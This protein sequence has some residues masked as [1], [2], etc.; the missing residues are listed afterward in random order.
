MSLALSLVILLVYNLLNRKL[1]SSYNKI[2]LNISN[3][4]L[5]EDNIRLIV[6]IVSGDKEYKS[7]FLDKIFKENEILHLLVLS[8]GNVAILIHF[9]EYNKARY[10][11]TYFVFK[12]LF[13]SEYFVFTYLQHP[14]ARALLFMLVDDI[15]YLWGFKFL[16]RT[17]IVILLFL[18]LITYI[19]LN[20]SLSFL[21]SSYFSLAILLFSTAMT[22]LRINTIYKF[23]IFSVYMAFI[24]LFISRIVF[25]SS[26]FSIILRSNFT[27]L[28]I[29]DFITFISY[30]YYLLI[31]ILSFF[32][33]LADPYSSAVNFVLTT[34]LIYLETLTNFR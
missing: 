9:M 33:L 8:G 24:S 28:P 31:P 20:F 14:V 27:V 34:L 5:A 11:K 10:S 26:N 22:K 16:N 6:L 2:L 18:A 1:Y 3:E 25:N 30:L 19:C 17:K 23:V 29:F 7:K 12:F 32:P 21:L 15:T 13:L 4:K